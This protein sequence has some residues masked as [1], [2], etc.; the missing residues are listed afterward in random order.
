M[1]F[2]DIVSEADRLFPNAFSE[3]EKMGFANDVGALIN[4][5]YIKKTKVYTAVGGEEFSLPP[6]VTSDLVCEVYF[7]DKKQSGISVA[8]MLGRSDGHNVKIVYLDVPT[9]TADDELPVSSPYHNLFLYY[10]LAFIC[11]HSGDSDGFNSNMT[12]YNTN[13][14]E[15][16][17]TFAQCE[18]K[19]LNFKNLW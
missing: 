15:Y 3:D 14:M 6:G 1:R 10:I 8:S 12:I 18:G 17:K 7:D 9:Y 5:K 2:R 11:L 19:S 16:E 4:R 13:L